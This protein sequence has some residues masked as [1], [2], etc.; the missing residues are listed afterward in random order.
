[1]EKVKYFDTQRIVTDGFGNTVD[2]SLYTELVEHSL[3]LQLHFLTKKKI[4][5]TFSKH[6]SNLSTHE[7][8]DQ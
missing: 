6:F 1:M 3:Q 5:Q 8:S 4:M 2:A 7:D